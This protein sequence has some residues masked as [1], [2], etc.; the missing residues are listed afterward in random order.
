MRQKRR[1]FN[2]E[3]RIDVDL[4]D[5]RYIFY[6]CNYREIKFVIYS[7]YDKKCRKQK[8]RN[9]GPHRQWSRWE[10]HWPELRKGIW[11][12]PPNIGRAINGSKRGWNGKQTRKD[13]EVCDPQYDNPWK[14]KTGSTTG[15]R[16]REAKDY[17]GFP[18]AEWRKPQHQL[19]NWRIQMAKTTFYNQKV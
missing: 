16:P 5:S 10:V 17:P 15:D 11:L 8:R 4:S 3:T 13:H 12:R 18:M 1:V 14:D 6:N 7:D 2:S 19:E 9:P